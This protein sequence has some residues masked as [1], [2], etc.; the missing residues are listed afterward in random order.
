MSRIIDGDGHIVEPPDLWL[1]YAHSSFHDRVP[2]IA[3]NADGIPTVKLE[4]K[5]REGVVRS[6]YS[7]CVPAGLVDEERMREI[8]FDAVPKGGWDPDARIEV[9][10][11]EGIE[12]AFLYPSMALGLGHLSDLDLARECARAYNDWLSDFCQPHPQRLYG[13]GMVPLQDVD[14]AI[15]EMRRVVRTKG[16]KCVFFRPNPYNGRR[17]NDPA[18]EPFWAAAEELDCAI[19]IH[20]SFG[21]RMPTVCDDRY[22]DDFYQH[23]I[24]HPFEQ[25]MCCMDIVCGGV[26]ERHPGLRVA[27]MEAGV[28]WLGYWLERMDGHFEAM[29]SFVP[30]LKK[31]PSEDFLEQCFLSC[32]PDDQTIAAM[33]E[34]GGDRTIIWGSDYPHYDCWFP[35][36]VAELERNC[37]RLSPSQRAQVLGE[38]AARLYKV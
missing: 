25:Q 13:I 18:Y 14:G 27:F 6:L 17:L 26:L 21:S 5:T 23:M 11:A 20:G 34:F 32:D 33:M 10:D 37:E 36:A 7:S 35:G 2:T 8:D 12:S 28:G 22:T 9:M 15:A 24:C 16:M 3:R 19:A 31:K 1:N 30:D 4:G 29:P 38:N